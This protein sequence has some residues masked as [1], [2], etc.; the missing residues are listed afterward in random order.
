MSYRAGKLKPFYYLYRLA[1][2]I[3]STSPR[4]YT[5]L[6]RPV[7]LLWLLAKV[8]AHTMVG[9][10]RLLNVYR[11]ARN[12]EKDG[13]PGSFVECG[14]WR[15]GCAAI[16]AKV[17]HEAGNRRKA[18]LFD[19]WEGLPEPTEKDGAEVRDHSNGRTTG[20]LVVVDKLAASKED[21]E[22]LLFH[23]LKLKRNDVMLVK[24]WFQD[25]LP[26]TKDKVGPIAILRLDAVLYE[27][28]KVCLEDLY[29]QVVSGGYV[30]I[31]DYGD[32][33]GCRKAV[34][35]FLSIRNLEVKLYRIDRR[36]GRYFV[37]P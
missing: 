34:D 15:G 20:E 13:I 7:L 27:S 28:T 31:D 14:I 21:A 35:E 2:I 17:A 11:L 16:M 12:A 33:D 32:W 29:D 10:A 6:A 4:E 25:T 18:W 5:G 24:G 22:H 8:R 1:R 9:P 36:A 23:T 19:S 30:I 3:L 37:K 26:M